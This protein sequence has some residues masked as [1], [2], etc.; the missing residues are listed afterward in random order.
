MGNMRTILNH[1]RG[2]VMTNLTEQ[3]KKGELSSGWYWV[4]LKEGTFVD[5]KKSIVLDYFSELTSSF[6]RH[7]YLVESV[8]APVPSFEQ[9]K[10]AQEQLQKDGVWYTEISHKKV[11]RENKRLKARNAELEDYYKVV[12]SY[13]GKPVDYDTASHIINKLLDEKKILMDENTKLKELLKEVLRH[14]LSLKEVSE[15]TRKIGE[16]LG[17]E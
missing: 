14:E 1:H 3:W 11:L 2:K 17:E 12:M 16:A 9:W 15:L 10:S 7:P 6:D 5:E 4:E 8:L 13:Y